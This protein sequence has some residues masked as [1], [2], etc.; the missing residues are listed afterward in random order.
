MEKQAKKAVHIT[1]EDAHGAEAERDN[2]RRTSCK[3]LPPS[4]IKLIT[5]HLSRDL[6]KLRTSALRLWSGIF[7]HR[8]RTASSREGL[9][10]S[11]FKASHGY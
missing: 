7:D 6:S 11:S 2:A 1:W 10:K 5:I 3:P 4:R 8:I 9:N